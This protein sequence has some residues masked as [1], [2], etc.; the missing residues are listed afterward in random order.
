MKKL[1]FYRLFLRG[2]L[3]FCT[4]FLVGCAS[5]NTKDPFESYN[6]KMFAFNEAADQYV[7]KPVAQ[8]YADYVPQG[9]QSCVSNFFRNL[10]EI[11]SGINCYLQ[12]K[13]EQGSMHFARVAMNTTFGVMGCF[14][15]ATAIGMEKYPLEDFGQTLGSYGVP[16][17][18]YIVLPFLGPSNLRDTS[19]TI[20][21]DF[22]QGGKKQ[23]FSPVKLNYKVTDL[24]DLSRDETR[25]LSLVNVIQLRA[26]F[27]EASNMLDEASTDK[28]S[29][30]RDAYLQ[31]R[32]NLV[33]DGE[34]PEK[35]EDVDEDNQK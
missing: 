27:L 13:V 20:G 16:A 32:N 7:L 25:V 5:T 24:W 6:R 33:Y 8:T 1:F 12:G 19:A 3:A 17:G 14:D 2:L 21:F 35:T 10:G 29:F 30:V 11:W 31:R 23:L 34:P 28:Y 18:P 26:G 15:V 22:S 4:L 9:A